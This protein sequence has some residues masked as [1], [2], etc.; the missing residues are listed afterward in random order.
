[1]TPQADFSK[2]RLRK[3]PNTGIFIVLG[4]LAIPLFLI[5][6][7]IRETITK[8]Q[9]SEPIDGVQITENLERGHQEGSISYEQSPP[10]GGV[11]NPAWQN[12]GVYL[13]VIAN[14]NAVHSLEHGAVW[15]AYSD[16]LPLNEIEQLGN[17]V[18]QSDFRLL[19]PFPSLPMPLVISAWG[20]QLWLENITDP[21]LD[22][23][24]EK[25][26]HGPNTP[27]FGAPCY[28]GVG[29]PE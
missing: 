4:L 27:E 16:E 13:E 18:R 6:V 29:T 20:A 23:F 3:K 21:R 10:V 19:S 25:Y 17:F 12:C 9:A 14:E 11:H 2:K 28:G 5:A 8:K 7:T 15:I 22:A 26:E 24:I 1:M